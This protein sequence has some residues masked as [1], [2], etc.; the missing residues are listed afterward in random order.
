Q[1]D[2]TVGDGIPPIG[3]VVLVGD[4]PVA[5]E[6]TTVTAGTDLSMAITTEVTPITEAEEGMPI[7]EF[8]ERQFE[9][10]LI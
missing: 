9:E 8:L 2:G 6:A 5:G 3:V 10:D 1:G 7:L 4:G